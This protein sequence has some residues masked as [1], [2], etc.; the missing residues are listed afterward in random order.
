MNSLCSLSDSPCWSQIPFVTVVLLASCPIQC[1]P[2][3]KVPA[4]AT[5]QD[6]KG[7]CNLGDH[8]LTSP[9]S[10]HTPLCEFVAMYQ[11]ETFSKSGSVPRRKWSFSGF[12]RQLF[13]ETQ[14]SVGTSHRGTLSCSSWPLKPWS[15]SSQEHRVMPMVDRMGKTQ[16]RN[17]HFSA[18]LKAGMVSLP[19]FCCVKF[20]WN[21]GSHFRKNISTLELTRFLDSTRDLG[22]WIW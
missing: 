6:R 16:R 12:S 8:I 10:P 19:T 4:V 2:S 20:C 1:E 13:G 21:L 7:L 5:I 14:R 9:C 15:C 11:C 18:H 22:G 3:C 17:A